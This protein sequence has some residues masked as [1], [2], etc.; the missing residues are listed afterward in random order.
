[1]LRKQC[2]VCV[3]AA[4]VIVGS[5]TPVLHGE[6]QRAT[7]YRLLEGTT[8]SGGPNALPPTPLTGSFCLV[9]E[10]EGP[11]LDHYRVTDFHAV[12]P[13][14]IEVIGQG[15]YWIGG[16][17][18]PDHQMVLDVTIISEEVHLDSGL[19]MTTS[20]FPM[21]E[22]TLVQDP[23]PEEPYVLHLI[24]VPFVQVWFSTGVE[25]HS[26]TH[27]GALITPG[28]LLNNGG[29]VIC[30]NACLTR[31]LGIAPP[32]PDIGLDALYPMEI[33]TPPWWQ[34]W[35]S[36]EETVWSETLGWLKHGDLLS[37]AGFVVLRN[38]DLLA[39]FE[40]EPPVADLGLDAIGSGWCYCFK[41]SV[42][43]DFWSMA[44]GDWVRHGDL[45]AEHGEVMRRNADLL[46]NF[47]P[48]DSVGDVGL[49]AV[50]VWPTGEVWFSTE[51]GFRDQVYDWISDGDLLS[52][53][54]WIV[55][56][57][58]RLLDPFAPIEDLDNFG[59]DA[60]HVLPFPPGDLNYDGCVN[61]S[62]LGIL[63]ADWGCSGGFCPGDCDFDG[64]TDQADLGILLANWGVDCP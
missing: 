53:S 12:S 19:V 5:I 3:C 59:L 13:D 26:G 37:E 64:D 54:G 41:F 18:P 32:V 44:L 63:L 27:G 50:Y 58:L 29:R 8:L 51:T 23:A 35:F 57:N 11:I 45:L 46:A 21:I 42:E 22:I 4:A 7:G 38:E 62:D 56:R 24:A 33:D 55:Y 20:W 15:D 36:A 52:D 28:D 16:E 10:E 31:N 1:M 17:L 34:Q 47:H 2:L 6:M 43:E 39:A 48:I 25:F 30:D 9:P 61:Q 40:P 14:F 49:D 60:L